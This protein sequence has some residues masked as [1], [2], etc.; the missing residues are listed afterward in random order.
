[1]TFGKDKAK[2][3]QTTREEIEASLR[4]LY[5]HGHPD[6]IRMSLDEMELHSKKN[7]DYA[8]GGDP[9]GNFTRVA[10][11][12]ENYPELKLSN[13]VVVGIVYSMK[14]LDQVLWSLN[15]G[16]EGEIEGIDTR[17]GDNSVYS[18]LEIILNR[19]RK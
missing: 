5:P 3:T 16:F 14:Q 11:I 17:L 6:F 7:Y 9:L 18:K 2:K 19:E 13:P 15:R 10:K 8:A 4:K 12:F 1:M